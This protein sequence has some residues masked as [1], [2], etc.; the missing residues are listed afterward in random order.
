MKFKLLGKSGLRVSE[1]G[2]GSMTLGNAWGWGSEKD[3]AKK[4]FDTFTDAG[5]NFLDTACNYQNGQSEQF[6]GEFTKED[7]DRYIIATKY[8][9]HDHKFPNDINAGGN[10]RKN[11]LRSMK[12]SL[13]RLQ[14]DYI[15]ILYMHVW[16]FTTGLEEILRTLNDLVSSTKVNYIGISDTPA[17]LV[18]RANTIAEF[19]GWEPFSVYQ[20]PYSIGKRDAEREIIPMCNNMDLA[21]TTWG[22]LK[23]GLFTGKYTRGEGA[24]GRAQNTAQSNQQLRNMAIVIDEIADEIGCNSSH[25]AIRW[26]MDQPGIVIPLIAG[27]NNEQFKDNLGALNITL[28]E[29]QN[30]IIDEISGFKPEFPLEF[31]NSDS[32]LKVIH[33]NTLGKLENHHKNY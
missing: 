23:A 1:L 9:L 24:T 5:G 27:R 2:L 29:D 14:T 25:V 33:S 32:V 7:R 22:T 10:H 8:T 11:L 21:M 20:F 31:I 12:D 28:N 6:I 18:S 16:D 30:K 3:E 15:D 19:R 17:W 13:E 26:V 4:I